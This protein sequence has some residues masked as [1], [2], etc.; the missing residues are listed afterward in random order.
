VGHFK[1]GN[2]LFSDGNVL[3][4]QDKKCLMPMVI[5]EVMSLHS[6]GDCLDSSF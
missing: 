5:L 4:T 6:G 3:T 1:A 2:C